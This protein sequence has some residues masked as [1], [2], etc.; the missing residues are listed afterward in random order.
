MSRRPREIGSDSRSS[1]GWREGPGH[2]P[3]RPR[4]G[5]ALVGL[6][7]GLGCGPARPEGAR[8]AERAKLELEAKRLVE[9]S[10]TPGEVEAADAVRELERFVR[11]APPGYAHDLALLALARRHLERGELDAATSDV[12]VLLARSSV[13]EAHRDRARL[14]EA[15]LETRKGRADRALRSLELLRGRLFE[16]S[17]KRF[18][19]REYLRAVLEAGRKELVLEALLALLVLENYPAERARAEA[20]KVLFSMDP[21]DLREMPLP[22]LSDKSRRL[23]AALVE[24]RVEARLAGAALGKRDAELAREVLRRNPA[25]LRGT[26]DY[27]ELVLLTK[28]LAD[29]AQVVG[30]RVGIVPRGQTPPAR[31][32]SLLLMAGFERELDV[33]GESDVS[34]V[35]EEGAGSV[36]EALS[37]LA[38][39]GALLL[40]AGFQESVALEALQFAEDRKMVVFVVAPPES[41]PP[42]DFGFVAGPS[43]G[44]SRRLLEEAATTEGAAFDVVTDADCRVSGPVEALLVDAAPDCLRRLVAMRSARR[45]FLGIDVSGEPLERGVVAFHLSSRTFP[46]DSNLVLSARRGQDATRPPARFYELLGRDL[47]RLGR[48]ALGMLPSTVARDRDVVRER[49]AQLKS[50]LLQVRVPLETTAARGFSET[51]TLDYSFEVVPRQG[52]REGEK[53]P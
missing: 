48:E 32:R 25:W 53:V 52:S 16:T 3:R 22:G 35:A 12:G 5:L 10:E 38:A 34:V 47:A 49:Y 26:P 30:R 50:S 28:L 51:R 18:F 14:L 17:E 19:A 33:L 39:D 7:V 42:L 41:V 46:G 31:S 27:E 11:Q 24:E 37:R 44:Y 6:L 45:Y 1:G 8:S 2:A 15:A 4:S 29:E 43:P 23:H 9:R 21:A 40:I 36:S 13:S 20:D